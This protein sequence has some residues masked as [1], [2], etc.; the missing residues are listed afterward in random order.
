MDVLLQVSAQARASARHSRWAPSVE[1][2]GQWP[3]HPPVL[4][5]GGKPGSS[6]NSQLRG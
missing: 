6:A 1:A 4:S 2:A 3:S 5:R